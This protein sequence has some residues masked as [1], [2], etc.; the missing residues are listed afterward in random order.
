MILKIVEFSR[1]HKIDRRIL[2]KFFASKNI[3][4]KNIKGMEIPDDALQGLN[5]WVVKYRIES[6]NI[7]RQNGL[8]VGKC[9]KNGRKPKLQG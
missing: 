5:E 4:P 6:K 3:I 9:G 8:K 1:E 7:Q 2:M